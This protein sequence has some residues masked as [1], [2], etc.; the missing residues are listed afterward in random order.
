[1]E[2][3]TTSLRTREPLLAVCADALSSAAHVIVETVR[4]DGRIYVFGNGGSAADAE[5]IVGELLKPFVR[6]RSLDPTMRESLSRMDRAFGTT[7]SESLRGGIPA[8]ALTGPASIIT[9]IANDMDQSLIFAQ[10]I[11]AL[12]RPGDACL[13][14]STS[15]DSA[16]VLNGAVAARALGGT[17]I[18]LTGRRGGRLAEAAS[19]AIRVPADETDRIQEYH[20]TAYHWLCRAVETALFPDDE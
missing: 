1:M 19:I 15:G 11:V 8:L 16:S 6:E 9:A 20:V 2:L 4:S 18:A 17:V 7:L 14:L 13:A 12:L 3:D 5:H 10:Q